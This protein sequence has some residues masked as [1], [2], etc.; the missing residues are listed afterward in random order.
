[1]NLRINVFI[2]LIFSRV[3]RSSPIHQLARVHCTLD[4][5][6]PEF[7]YWRRAGIPFSLYRLYMTCKIHDESHNHSTMTTH[8][9]YPKSLTQGGKGA[10]PVLQY[11][12]LTPTYST[13]TPLYSTHTSVVLRP[14]S[15]LLH[16]TPP[17]LRS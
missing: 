15:S 13:L 3:I 5:T 10:T 11:S 4:N 7:H 17:V 9:V 16:S 6:P 1:V 8:P 2:N 12:T 14:Y